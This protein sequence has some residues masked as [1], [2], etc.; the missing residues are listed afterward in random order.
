MLQT[1]SE[2]NVLSVSEITGQVKDVIDTSFGMLWIVGEVSN[3]R[4]QSSGHCYFTLKDAK[5]QLK[6]VMWRTSAA[7]VPVLPTDGMQILVRGTMT[8]YQAYGQYQLVADYLQPAGIGALQQAFEALKAKL[9]EE[10]L[11]DTE[12]K[13]PLPATPSVVGVVT[14][15]TGAAVR[16][17]ITVVSRRMPS[18][19]IIV[20]PARV[21]GQGAAEDIA[22]GIEEL[23]AHGEADVL[24]VGRGGGSVEDLWC[25]SEER[26]VRAVV[27]SKIPTVSAVG[28][29]IDYSLSDYAAD[30][31]AP[32]PSAAAE[33]VV[34]DVREQ[35]Q[36]VAA[37]H[38]ELITRMNYRVEDAEERI[39]NL[40]DER[41]ATR[42]LDRVNRTAQDIDRLADDM[43]RRTDR[44]VTRKTSRLAELGAKL[45]ALSPLK[46]LSRG[47]AVCERDSDGKV[48]TSASDVDPKDRFR[49]R[50]KQGIILGIVES[51]LG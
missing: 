10:G 14:S 20:R 13:R 36:Y 4:R 3:F 31:R 2:Q 17:I 23:N 46:V 49:V 8:V 21:Q 42:L 40:W 18:T 15:G 38:R 48:I 9:S 25:F 27:A 41:I 24:I 47:Y 51:R 50:L 26:V 1:P 34:P 5:A 12:R 44:I 29:E 37:L 32:T 16:D 6:C 35:I 45:D 33:M 39:A 11:F 30:M 7:R 28:H 22:Q 19:R 43:V